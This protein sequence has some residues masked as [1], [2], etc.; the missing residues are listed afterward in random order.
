MCSM[1]HTSSE[2]Q[3]SVWKLWIEVKS[4]RISA[5][6][7]VKG[8]Y[9]FSD[10]KTLQHSVYFWRAVQN[11]SETECVG[12]HNEGLFI[13]F[14][15]KEIGMH[16]FHLFISSTLSKKEGYDEWSAVHWLFFGYILQVF[17]KKPQK[18]IYIFSMAMYAD[19]TKFDATTSIPSPRN[20]LMVQ[21]ILTYLTT[22]SDGLFTYH[23]IPWLY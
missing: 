13:S 21:P 8:I 23:R 22:W 6:V 18:I 14:K 15:G 5:S 16:I 10:S 11:A 3:L 2:K 12:N 7:P 20:I 19:K 1:L 9:F 4:W 17:C